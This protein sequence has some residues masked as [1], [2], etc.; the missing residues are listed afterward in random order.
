VAEASKAR[1]WRPCVGEALADWY[2][3]AVEADDDEPTQ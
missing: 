3:L 1:A 2:V